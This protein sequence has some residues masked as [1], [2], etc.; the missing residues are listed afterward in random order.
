MTENADLTSVD[1]VGIGFGPANMALAIAAEE[2]GCALGLRFLERNARAGWQ[3]EMLLPEA[4]I[5][6]HRLRDLATPRNPRS[7]YTFANFLF[8]NDRLFEHLNLPLHHPLRVEYRQ[9]VI[10]V[11]NQFANLVRYGSNVESIVPIMDKGR[12]ASY[13]V[14]YDGGRKVAAK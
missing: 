7:R 14:R 4:D 1:V 2:L 3:D 13:E 10:W 5:Q 11:A 12:I 6:H 9:Y 8:E